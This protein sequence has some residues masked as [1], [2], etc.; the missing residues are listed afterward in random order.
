MARNL[1]LIQPRPSDTAGPLSS[2]GAW[3][4]VQAQAPE[5]RFRLRVAK[6]FKIGMRRR[7]RHP[8]CNF[9]KALNSRDQGPANL[10][11]SFLGLASYG[12]SLKFPSFS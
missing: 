4:S 9:S 5:A 10:E 6:H 2:Y 7:R 3:A 12:Q 11:L 8:S 1:L